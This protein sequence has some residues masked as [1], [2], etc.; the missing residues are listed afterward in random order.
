MNLQGAYRSGYN[1]AKEGKKPRFSRSKKGELSFARKE[2]EDA[3]LSGYNDA[4]KDMR[5]SKVHSLLG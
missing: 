3:Y 2:Y 5:I 4:R 1:D